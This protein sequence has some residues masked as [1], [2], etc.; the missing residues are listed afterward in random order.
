MTEKLL[1]V[2]EMNASDIMEQFV[3]INKKITE[4]AA[5]VKPSDSITLLCPKQMIDWLGITHPT[6]SD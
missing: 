2:S 4:L 3:V 5:H 6:L 1:R